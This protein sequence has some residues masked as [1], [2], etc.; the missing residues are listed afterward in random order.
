ML[1][2]LYTDKGDVV[3]NAATEAV[4]AIIKLFPPKSAGQVFRV[5]EYVIDE[6]KWKAKVGALDGIKSFVKTAKEAVANELG[7]MLPKV[8]LALHDTKTEVSSA[9]TKYVT[10]LCTTLANPDL[11][12]DIP[13]PVKCISNPVQVPECI[14]ALSCLQHSSLRSMEVQRRT[15]IVT[16]NLVK[17]VRDLKVAAS[18]LSSLVGGVER[19]KETAS[20]PEVRAFA[21]AAHTLLKAGASSSG[22]S[23]PPRDL[24]AEASYALSEMLALLPS[25]LIPPAQQTSNAPTEVIHPIL[26]SSL[27]FCSV[28]VADLVY[29]DA[30]LEDDKPKWERSFGVFIVPW[31][32]KDSNETA[33]SLADCAR[34]PF[35]KGYS[36]QFAPSTA[37]NNGEDVLCDT[38][39]SLAYRALL[40][41]LHHIASCLR[42]MLRY[43]RAKWKRQVDFNEISQ[44]GQG[45][46]LPS[47]P[48]KLLRTV[49]VE[50]SLQGEDG[51][52]SII[53]FIAADS[54]L[55]GIPR[56]K[57]AERLEEVGF[58]EKRQLDTVGG[59][60]GGWKMKL[61]LARAVLYNADL[62]L[63]DEPTNHLDK[64]SVKWLERYLIAQ[65]NVTCLILV[66]YPRNL[67]HFVEQHSEAK[68]YYTLA[69]TSIKFSFPPPSSLMGVRSSTRAIL[70]MSHYTFTYPGRSEPSLIDVSC[71][72][73]LSSRVGIVGPNGAGKSAL[74]KLLAGETASRGRG[75]HASLFA[76]GIC[77]SACNSPHKSTS[78]KDILFINVISKTGMAVCSG[79]PASDA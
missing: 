75:I 49:M 30:F 43:L 26:C 53:D 3:R 28:M 55:A 32:A 11:T 72:L 76:C 7:I 33:E 38:L 8:K 34:K 24:A 19:I 25:E 69:A 57:I 61:E 4:K 78:G 17:L 62:L 46:K 67:S 10:A 66:Y 13:L 71:A 41:L 14:K 79:L 54:K 5:L 39:F 48:Q 70:K 63:L 6:G 68:S 21:A 59:L 42:P 9:A 16:D 2:D 35:H 18:Y 52:L 15:V 37:T 22:A 73:S 20:F 44:R 77:I 1:Y 64:A 65:K 47:P 51:S 56:S 27:E 36:A 40:L 23:P 50:H 58:D 29:E 60:S 74:I 31:L 12:P 45:G